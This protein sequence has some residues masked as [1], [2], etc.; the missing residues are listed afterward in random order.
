MSKHRKPGDRVYVQAAAAFGAGGQWGTIMAGGDVADDG[1]F[2]PWNP[3]WEDGRSQDG[4]MVCDDPECDE[5]PNLA[6]DGG[7]SMFHVSECQMH[8][9]EPAVSGS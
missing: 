9:A 8:D 4:C 1:K 6:A 2:Y 7:G 3:I 5:W